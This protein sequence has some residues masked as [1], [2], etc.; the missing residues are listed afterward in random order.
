MPFSTPRLLGP[1]ISTVGGLMDILADA[2]T[3][4]PPGHRPTF[5][6]VMVRL[7]LR[8]V[9]RSELGLGFGGGCFGRGEF[10]VEVIVWRIFPRSISARIN[11]RT[12]SR[13]Y[14]THDWTK[15]TGATWHC[16]AFK[17]LIEYRMEIPYQSEN[18]CPSTEKLWLAWKQRN[19]VFFCLDIVRQWRRYHKQVIRAQQWANLAL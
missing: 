2:R 9:L 18:V 3:N 4:Y 11:Y 7:G 13:H 5:F 12:A 8:L 1:L 10:C 17:R 6:G 15:R 16:V 14:S 19:N